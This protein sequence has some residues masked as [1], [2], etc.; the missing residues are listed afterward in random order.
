MKKI[1]IN[2]VL[3][4]G[5]CLALANPADA[6]SYYY[7]FN[8][9]G[10]T[11]NFYVISTLH[12]PIGSVNKFK[13][14]I[15]IK[16][17]DKDQIQKADGLLEIP[18]AS[19]FTNQSMRDNRMHKETLD[20]AKYPLITFKVNNAKITNNT[21]KQN[22][23]MN[24]TLIGPLTIHGVS[25]NAQIPVN[26]KLAPDKETATVTGAY[27]VNFKDYGMPDPSIP[28]VGKVNE[29]VKVTFNLKT[30]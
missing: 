29:N 23:M 21:L 19:L 18:A 10:S 1:I 16:A 2:S 12:K 22:G 24:V 14:Y 17:D 7:K 6:K 27:D 25:R 11:I 13:G 4:G 15:D 8:E 28:L 9:K 5:M 26:V 20:V 30:Y 3:L